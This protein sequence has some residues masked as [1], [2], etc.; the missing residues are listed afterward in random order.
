VRSLVKELIALFFHTKALLFVGHS[1]TVSTAGRF[2]LTCLHG[3]TSPFGR[4]KLDACIIEIGDARDIDRRARLRE[5]HVQYRH[6]RLPAGHDAR[7]R[8]GAGEQFHCLFSAVGSHIIEC[9]GLHC[10]R[11]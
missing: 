4:F 6:Q 10:R 8:P 11:P 2:R 3:L 9:L 7:I 1:L 5:P